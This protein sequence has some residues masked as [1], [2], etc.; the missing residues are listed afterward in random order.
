MHRLKYKLGPMNQN[1]RYWSSQGSQLGCGKG[2]AAPHLARMEAG[3]E[4]ALAVLGAAVRKGIG[5]D[6]AVALRLALERIVANRGGG[7][8]RRLDVARLDKRWLA[9]A[10]PILVLLRRP[11]AGEAIGLQLHLHLDVVGGGPAGGALRLLRLGQDA[12]Q[13]LH[14]VSDLV[15]DHIGLR[16]LAGLAAEVAERGVEINRLVDRAIER[17]HGALRDAAARGVGHPAIEHQHRRAISLAVLGEDFLPLQLSAAEHPAYEGCQ[18]FRQFGPCLPRR[19][20]LE[21]R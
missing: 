15:R 1:A 6:I 12:Q 4:P 16:E 13:V 7:A 18:R 14:L 21:R 3:I 10:E 20:N 2:V 9:L 17:P 11:E 8:Q 19:N 5:N